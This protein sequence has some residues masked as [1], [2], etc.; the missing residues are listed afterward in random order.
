MGATGCENVSFEIK[1]PSLELPGLSYKSNELNPLHISGEK[2]WH[3]GDFQGD[4]EDF[5][6]LIKDESNNAHA[7][8]SRGSSLASLGKLKEAIDDANKAIELDPKPA[9]A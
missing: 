3:S 2:K 9:K 1:D 4:L 8:F 7:Y 6:Q 5:D